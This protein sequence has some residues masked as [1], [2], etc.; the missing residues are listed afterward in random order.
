M[1]STAQSSSFRDPSG[2][3]FFKDNILYRNIN[4]SYISTYKSLVDAHFFETLFQK[5]WL[6]HHEEID[7]TE[8]SI[9][10][11]PE[12]IPFI[13]YPYEWSFKQ[14]KHAALLTLEIQ[15][16]SLER[17]F[18]LK[19]ASAFNITFHQGKA[20]FIDTL[21]FQKYQEGK[22]WKALRQF[23]THFYGPLLLAKY[24]G[25]RYLETLRL[26][27]DGLSLT[28]YSKLLPWYTYLNSTIYANVHLL[29]RFDREY[30]GKEDVREVKAKLSKKAQINML[31]SLINSIKKLELSNKGEWHNYY[32][33]ANYNSE[34]F[35][36]KKDILNNWRSKIGAERIIDLGG[37]DGTFVRALS[38]QP[39]MA[40][41][42]DI[43]RDAVDA[44]YIK[45][46]KQKEGFITAFVSNILQPSPAIGFAN[47]E[48]FSLTNRLM[49]WSP[50]CVFALALVHH[51]SLT[52]NVPFER[53]T[54]YLSNLSPHLI[55]EF[56]K[57]KDSWVEYI[58]KSKRDARVLFDFYN[59]NNFENTFKTYFDLVEKTDIIK[60]ERTLYLFKS[61]SF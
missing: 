30:D 35:Q 18:S 40:L 53:L 61:K 6:I 10:L 46:L 60:S 55:I 38:P 58:L 17:G 42:P 37:N 19:D 45:A 28:E 14:Y 5:N 2:Y 1:T 39:K 26:D 22:P 54:Q 9:V 57:R 20:I 43:D 8:N 32:D 49:Q 29:A 3:L 48:R 21:S 27:I 56:P 31:N 59:Q 51:I 44:N 33:K 13:T 7:S 36:F 24:Y 4:S 41:V 15:K 47:K 11:K 50:D 25:N 23:I 12:F 52:G 16:L 34:S